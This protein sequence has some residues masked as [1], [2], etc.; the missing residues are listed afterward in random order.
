MGGQGDKGL[1][2]EEYRNQIMYNLFGDESEDEVEDP[3]NGGGEV[4]SVNGNNKGAGDEANLNI[5]CS[6]HLPAPAARKHAYKSD[7]RRHHR[8]EEGHA[9]SQGSAGLAKERVVEAHHVVLGYQNMPGNVEVMNNEEEVYCQR[10]ET[11]RIRVITSEFEGSKDNYNADEDCKVNEVNRK[12]KSGPTEGDKA[13]GV[14]CN[15]FAESDEDEIAP[16]GGQDD[17]ENDNISP[18]EDEGHYGNILQ[19]KDI[20]SGKTTCYESDANVERE[21]KQRLV[22]PSLNLVVP[23]I[24]PPGQPDRMNVIRVSNVVGIDPKPF[25]PETY[26]EEDA[27]ITDES[28]GKKRIHLNVVR[29]RTVKNA[30]G[31][32]SPESNAR[33]VK[34]KD[35]SMQLLIGD[36]ALDVTVDETNHDTHLFMKNGKGLLQSQGRLLQKMRFM[37]SSLSSRS[38]RSLTALV[39]SQNKKTTKVQT[40]YNKTDPERAKQEMERAAEKDIRAR[41]NLRQKREKLNRKYTQPHRQKQKLTPGIL[42]E[43]L[44]QNEAPGFKY[45]RHGRVAHSGFEHDLEL[46]ALPER[47]MFNAK[48]NEYSDSEREELEYETELEDIESSPTHGSENELDEKNGYDQDLEEALGFTSVSDGDIEEQEPKREPR[49]RGKVIDSDDES[50]PPRKQPRNRGKAYVFYSDDDE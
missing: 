25:N 11:S 13:H 24:P 47:R 36:E 26:E 38:H 30:D 18:T 44:H 35:G 28:E 4:T 37:P 20:V 15:V 46:E 40:C 34:W 1:S 6:L 22:G 33:F 42:E 39:D 48:A 9:E 17:A 45:N 43:P 3:E 23:H 49:K 16:Y 31:T 12:R 10:I 21:S 19:G 50:P 41:S 5:T 32:E 14:L 7:S 29:W 27:L 2:L 8:S